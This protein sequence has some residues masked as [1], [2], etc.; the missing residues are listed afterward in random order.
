MDNHEIE[1]LLVEDNPDDA[2]L[3]IAALRKKDL[4]T[5]LIHLKDGVEALDFI[6]GTGA[7][8][9]RRIDVI[10]KVILLDLKM[11][12]LNGLEVLEK[13]KSDPQ[14]A[15]IP[16]VVLTSSF[17]DSD[18]K[19]AYQLGANSFIVKPVEFNV[20]SQTVADV[21]VYWVMLNQ[22]SQ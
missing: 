14:T 12:R 20:F 7:Y 17:E 8:E 11:P 21:G 16:I 6:Y 4:A 3:T 5:K 22:G 2:L 18:V 13:I 15:M 10:P 9:G 1:I 19:R